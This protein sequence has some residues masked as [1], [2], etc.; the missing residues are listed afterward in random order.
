M[1]TIDPNTPS[2]SQA[3]ASVSAGVV[4]DHWLELAGRF[5]NR[6]VESF[7][8]EVDQWLEELTESLQQFESPKSRGENVE[9][10]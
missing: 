2:E 1:N 7:G 5:R 4:A 3:D 8:L 9:R 10:R 6:S